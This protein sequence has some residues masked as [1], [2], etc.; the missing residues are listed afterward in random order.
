MITLGLIADRL[1]TDA[2]TLGFVPPAGRRIAVAFSAL[3]ASFELSIEDSGL[4]RHG[5]ARCRTNG[6][7]IAGDS[8]ASSVAGWSRRGS[9]AAAAL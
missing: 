1:L 4:V 3:E 7:T 6:V 2:N 9:S 8:S 5:T